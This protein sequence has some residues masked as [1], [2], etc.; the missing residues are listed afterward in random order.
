[1]VALLRAR[2]VRV[3]YAGVE[4]AASYTVEFEGGKLGV[5]LR[6]HPAFEGVDLLRERLVVLQ[7]LALAERQQPG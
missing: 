3:L 5:G 4:G 1:M 6:L 2:A 7:L